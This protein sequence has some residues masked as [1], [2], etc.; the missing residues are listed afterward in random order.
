MAIKGTKTETTGATAPKTPK[1]AAPRAKKPVAAPAPA[2]EAPVAKAV[3]PV[4]PKPAV[5][6][7]PKPVVA[8]APVAAP[9]PAAPAPL[10]AK[11]VVTEAPAIPLPA[12]TATV[13]EPVLPPP[14]AKPAQSTTPQKEVKIMEN[15]VQ[16]TQ[17]LFADMNERTKAAM[18]KST[19]LF[20][21]M[22][23]FGKGNVEALVESSKV[24]IKGFETIGQDAAEYTRKSFEGATAAM[25]NLA[26]VKTPAEMMKLHTDYVRASFDQLV[27]E[28]SKTTESMLKLAGEIAQPISNR[29]AVAAE[30]IKLDA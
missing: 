3:A 9:A 1:R 24:A 20:A 16:Q 2:A 5:V 21:E 10:A 27:A 30:K 26:S 8:A 29:V 13:A 22:N 4:A 19:K 12:A 25:R 14:A 6:A 15:T 11:P 28:T 23:D 7:A 18:E 17:A